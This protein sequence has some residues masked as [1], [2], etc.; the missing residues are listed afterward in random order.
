M[1]L[2][3]RRAGAPDELL[4]MFPVT[5]TIVFAPSIATAAPELASQ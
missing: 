3:E 2:F 1:A 5:V 4:T